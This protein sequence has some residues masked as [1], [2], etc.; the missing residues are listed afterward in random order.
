MWTAASLP[1]D[2]LSIENAIIMFGSRRWPLMIDQYNQANKFL[3]KFGS[4]NA[5]NEMETYKISDPAL[6]KMLELGIQFGRWFLVEN[7]G[8]E[9]DPALDP[10]LMK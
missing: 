8:T 7:V 3:K 9:L 6:M 4:E 1:N 10:I 5:P 2:N